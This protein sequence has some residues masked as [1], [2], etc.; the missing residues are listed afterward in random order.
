MKVSFKD[1]GPKP[2][3]GPETMKILAEEQAI[4]EEKYA[5]NKTNKD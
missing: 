5:T 3:F 4:A 2:A 1:V